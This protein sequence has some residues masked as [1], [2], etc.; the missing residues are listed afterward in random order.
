MKQIHPQ[1]NSKACSIEERFISTFFQTADD[2][3]LLKVKKRLKDIEKNVMDKWSKHVITSVKKEEENNMKKRVYLVT[4]AAGFLG[5]TVCRMLINQG[6]EVRGLVLPNDPYSKYVPEGVEICFGD[7]CDVA[8]LERFFQVGPDIETVVIHVASIVTVNPDYN[9]AL[10]DVNVTGTQ[11]IIDQV[12]A[13]DEC[14]KLVYVGSTGAIPSLKKPQQL[15]E[16]DYYDI[17]NIVGWYSKSK[18]MAANLILD[19]VRDK[20]LQACI[21]LPTGILG[22][23]DFSNSETTSTIIKIANGDMSVGINGSFNLADVRDLAQACIS[24]VDKGKSGES[25][26]IGNDEVSFK[27]MVAIVEDIL[28]KKKVKYYL[29]IWLAKMVARQMEKK[30]KKTGEKPML[31]QYSIYNLERNNRFDS[32]KAKRDLGYQTRSFKETVREE[33]VWLQEN[34]LIA[35]E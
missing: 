31:T 24:A 32:S 26:I 29:P 23:E 6:Q 15:K 20:E 5:S 25:Y 21:V 18:G 1:V 11:N 35:R 33:I 12:L 3:R 7:L 27:D 4:G 34:H 9:Q 19:A 28:G 2:Y 8:S 16:V 30:S 10:I 17:D 22:P 13:H 14:T